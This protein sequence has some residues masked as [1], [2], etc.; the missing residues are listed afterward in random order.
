MDK[1]YWEKI[2]PRYDEEIF[3]VLHN[4]KSGK[5]VAAIEEIASKEKTVID[6]GCAIGK[7]IPLLAKQ[8]KFVVAADIS[9]TNL[10]IAKEKNAE[11]TN[12]EYAAMDMSADT[13]MITPCD[14]AICIN[15]ILTDSL[16]KRINFFQALNLS[17]N[18][19]GSLVLVV[20]SLESKLYTNIIANR[21]NVDGDHD[22]K[23]GSSK[24]AYAL[25]NNIKQGVTDID[26][27]P[28]KHYLKEELELLL[29]L[30]GFTVHAVEKINYTWKTEFTAPPKWLKE[31]YPWDWMCL[32]QKNS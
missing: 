30:E 9:V 24:K 31:P 1:K 25:A 8:F 22:E 19:N 6:I 14:V 20:P 10:Q 11:F 4:D 17:I 15:A 26:N 13:L 21:W 28:T 7:W 12:V 16:E 29:A 3:D 23:I 32:A 2:A 18:K 27:V 5:I